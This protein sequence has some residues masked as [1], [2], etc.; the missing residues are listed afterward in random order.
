MNA[1]LLSVLF[2]NSSK[3]RNIILKTQKSFSKYT[4]EKKLAE[5]LFSRMA[6]KSW[7]IFFSSLGIPYYPCELP[8]LLIN[9]KCKLIRSYLF[10]SSLGIPYYTCEL[11]LLLIN[12][13]CKL[14]RS[15]FKK[16]CAYS[17]SI[18]QNTKVQSLLNSHQ[19]FF[20]FLLYWFSSVH[21][22]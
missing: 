16:S 14:I 21:I 3:A 8:L 7:Q 11:P 12:L 10:F 2:W 1:M 9:L 19:L 4:V 13:K 22:Y 5:W 17:N 15:Y 20:T 18:G 6:Q